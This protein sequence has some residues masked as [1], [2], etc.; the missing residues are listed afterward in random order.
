[1]S[2]SNCKLE[3]ELKWKKYCVFS[4]AG[5]ENNINENANASNIL[6]SK[7]KLYVPVLT[8]SLKDNQKLSALFSK[9]FDRSVYWNEYKTKSDYKNMTNEFRYFL[10]SILLESIDC[11]F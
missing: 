4:V 5:N 9:R 8:L 11:L 3:L 1:M 6:L 10:E 7:T 2:L